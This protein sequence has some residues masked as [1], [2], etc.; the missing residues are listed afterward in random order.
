MRERPAHRDAVPV[1]QPVQ[2]RI[3]PG[4]A[5]GA[6]QPRR[7]HRHERQRQQQRADQSKADRVGHR[8][9]QPALDAL[10]G[11]QREVRGHDDEQRKEDRPLHLDRGA[12]NGLVDRRRTRHPLPLVQSAK[13]VLD[14]DQIAV[15]D[16]AEVD[17]AEAE[18]VGGDLHRVHARERKQQRQRDGDRGQQ[19]RPDAAQRERQHHDD[20]DERLGQRAGDRPQR[21]RD[22]IGAVVDPDD[23]DALRQPVRVEI[24]D[25]V[26]NGAQ[27]LAGILP[28]PHEHG[29]LDAADAI[30]Q[31]ED[32]GLRRRANGHAAGVP[33]Q[34]GHTGLCG[35]RD[36]PDVVRGLDETDTPDDH[37]L[38]AAAHQR[39]AR[40]AV[41][42]LHRVGD[43]G[44]GELVLLERE[45]IHL[46]VVFLDD[47]AEGHD[48]GDA[49]DLRQPRRDDPVLDLAEIHIVAAVGLARR[50][51]RT[52]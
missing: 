10:Q 21:V 52:R 50:S 12:P 9:E 28:A 3:P 42:H 18:Q 2:H 27:D 36:V 7:Q 26:V 24:V 8:R 22:Q 17:R 51:G 4:P 16:D 19:R 1:E 37:R 47:A 33:Q 13:D 6:K 23:P 39:A 20:D 41:V 34:H 44:D 49:L 30:V 29:A 14:H 43:L 46:D 40:I 5:T 38:L 11:E 48:V 32:A 35:Q 31:A 45:G 25:R 15:D